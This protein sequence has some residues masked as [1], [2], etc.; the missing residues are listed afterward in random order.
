MTTHNPHQHNAFEGL[1]VI[2][3]II[4]PHSS[5]PILHSTALT[6]LSTTTHPCVYRCATT[7]SS[8]LRNSGP[9]TWGHTEV[10]HLAE[11]FLYLNSDL[12]H[13]IR[14]TALLRGALVIISSYSYRPILYN[15][16]LASPESGSESFHDSLSILTFA[17]SMI[18][19]PF[20]RFSSHVYTLPSL[21][22]IYTRL[23]WSVFWITLLR[24]LN[25][26]LEFRFFL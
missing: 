22:I 18:L 21:L 25:D 16:F 24:L 17:L 12:L 1:D 20:C 2:Y 11:S 15:C 14:C 3:S 23:G 26:W 6:L 19:L 10:I 5:F 8:S 4:Y 9:W 13:P 7:D